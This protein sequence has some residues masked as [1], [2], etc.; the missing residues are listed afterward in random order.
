MHDPLVAF[1]G[2]PVERSALEIRVNF[3]IFAGR[4]A[5]PAEIDV[6]ARTL[7][8]HVPSV[9]IVAEQRF[10]VATGHEATVHQ[11]RVEVAA[12]DLPADEA[13][14]ETVT[15][16]LVEEAGRWAEECAAERSADV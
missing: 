16:R 5:T 8:V 14:L 3:G 4:E 1:A 2:P 9:T 10:E 6:L 11:V 7:L 15:R 13:E 12:A